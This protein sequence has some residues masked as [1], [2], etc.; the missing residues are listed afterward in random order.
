[1]SD[2]SKGS[3]GRA[4]GG[5]FIFTLNIIPLLL[6]SLHMLIAISPSL[7]QPSSSLE[8]Y[9]VVFS[10]DFNHLVTHIVKYSIVS[11]YIS[12]MLHEKSH[13]DME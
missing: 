7:D 2:K 3:E 8:G 6:P 9:L 13:E 10:V 11:G 5:A 4:E 12:F 1:M